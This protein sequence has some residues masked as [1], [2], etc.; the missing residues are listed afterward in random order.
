[1]LSPARGHVRVC[2]RLTTT[3]TTTELYH[4]PS[5]HDLDSRSECVWVSSLRGVGGGCACV[6]LYVSLTRS[7]SSASS[8]SLSLSRSL[9]R[10]LRHTR[11]EVCQQLNNG[12]KIAP[13]SPTVWWEVRRCRSR[14][15]PT[16]R[17]TYAAT[18]TQAAAVK[19]TQARSLAR[20]VARTLTRSVGRSVGRGQPEETRRARELVNQSVG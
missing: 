14:N 17:S 10:S 15:Q 4:L 7:V 16:S 6:Y 8:L 19:I 3:T 18:S 13:F 11:T 20:S 12:E 5:K 1:M 2:T 9:P